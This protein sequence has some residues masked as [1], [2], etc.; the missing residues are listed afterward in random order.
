MIWSNLMQHFLGWEFGFGFGQARLSHNASMSLLFLF[1]MLCWS[2]ESSQMISLRQNYRDHFLTSWCDDCNFGASVS[3]I[4]YTIV[5]CYLYC[6]RRLLIGWWLDTHI[7]IHMVLVTPHTQ[8]K[9][10]VYPI[11]LNFWK[12]SK[13]V[14]QNRKEFC[15]FLNWDFSARWGVLLQNYYGSNCITQLKVGAWDIKF[16]YYMFSFNFSCGL[17]FRYVCVWVT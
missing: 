16:C 3:A 8:F 4:W 9:Y 15:T 7:Y 5:G 14:Y 11:F 2:K 6:L 10:N 13:H 12:P 1:Y 17:G